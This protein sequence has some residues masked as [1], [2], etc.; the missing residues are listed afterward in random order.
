[1]NFH[2]KPLSYTVLEMRHMQ[3]YIEDMEICTGDF[4][5]L[6][7]EDYNPNMLQEEHD[8]YFTDLFNILSP[9]WDYRAC[10]FQ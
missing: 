10:E 5:C 8:V 1:M 7:Q 3:I 6:A 2:L 4:R 9:L